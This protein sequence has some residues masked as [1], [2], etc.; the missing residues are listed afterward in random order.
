MASLKIDG[1]HEV[2]Y[3]DYKVNLETLAGTESFAR[4]LTLGLSTA[5]KNSHAGLA[6]K[7]KGE[8]KDEAAI[9][10]A[11]KEKMDGK[12]DAILKGEWNAREASGEPSLSAFQ[13]LVR[14]IGMEAFKAAW[15]K[16]PKLGKAGVTF[17]ASPKASAEEKAAHAE[18]REKM[19][20][21]FS[22]PER[23]A[24]WEAEARRRQETVAPQAADEDIFAGL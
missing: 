9:E 10:A 11:I 16:H 12:F 23:V 5:L 4:L 18:K 8:G 15:A 22:T 6:A 1:S 20:A 17:N 13:R 3:G 24:A 2:S 14:S 19:F 21:N 7:L